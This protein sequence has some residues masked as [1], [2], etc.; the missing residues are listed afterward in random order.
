MKNLMKT[1]QSSSKEKSEFL[2]MI[3]EAAKRK[4]SFNRR[5]LNKSSNHDSTANSTAVTFKIGRKSLGKN[6]K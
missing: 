3:P 6:R 4:K 5:K 1:N 2:S